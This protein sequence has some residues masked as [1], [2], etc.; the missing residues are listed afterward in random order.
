MDWAKIVAAVG[1]VGAILTVIRKFQEIVSG[2]VVALKWTKGLFNKTRTTTEGIPT[3]TVV[4][5]Q[6]TQINSL[7]WHQGT[8]ADKPMLQVCGDFMV[9][10]TWTKEIKLPAAVL[11]CRHGLFRRLWRGEAL[12]KDVR[13]PYSGRYGIPPN[14]MTAIRFH[15]TV[16]N[17]A[18]D[19]RKPLVADIIVID[20]FNNEHVLK[21]LVFRNTKHILP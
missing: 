8:W 4:L 21:G 15:F 17:V 10:N 5:I 18:R 3:S 2:L 11:R 7:W 6:E 16:P 12:V 20:Q 14:E 9:T 13:G 1:A 19:E